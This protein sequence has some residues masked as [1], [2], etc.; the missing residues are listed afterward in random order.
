MSERRLSIVLPGH[1]LRG[2]APL[3]YEKL[4]KSCPPHGKEHLGLVAVAH[5]LARNA[6]GRCLPPSAL[7]QLQ[8]AVS[9]LEAFLSGRRSARESVG[10]ARDARAAA[11]AALPTLELFTSS[12]VLEAAKR[13]PNGERTT[14]HEHAQ[15]TLGRMLGLSV[16]HAVAALCH[17]LDAIDDREGCL[18]VPSDACGA[19]AY[20]RTALGSARNPAFQLAALEQARWEGDRSKGAGVP[21]AALEVQV[22]HEY[23]GARWRAHADEERRASDD[24]IAWA[25]GSA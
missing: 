6:L 24:F 5:A 23:L 3:V 15:H 17:T 10:L 13:L 12:A 11:F 22:F 1:E 19:L 9:T 16:H 2:H 4:A 18:S 14:L 20:S 8:P 25:L 7:V 21:S